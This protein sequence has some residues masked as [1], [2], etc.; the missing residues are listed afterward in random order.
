[1]KHS[2]E[3]CADVGDCSFDVLYQFITASR[4]FTCCG[5]VAQRL[6]EIIRAVPESRKPEHAFSLRTLPARPDEGEGE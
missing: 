4:T 6:K 5:S 2:C 1:M 3:F